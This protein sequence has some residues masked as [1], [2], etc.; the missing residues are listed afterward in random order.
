[1]ANTSLYLLLL[2]VALVA[3]STTH[4]VPTLST[5]PQGLA[6]RLE[7]LHAS[8]SSAGGSDWSQLKGCSIPNPPTAAD[9]PEPWL[10]RSNQTYT[11]ATSMSIP[12]SAR[13]QSDATNNEQWVNT[14]SFKVDFV[15]NA[16]TADFCTRAQ[17]AFISA[18]NRI[19]SEVKIRRP[20]VVGA[21]FFLPCGKSNPPASCAENNVLGAATSLQAIPVKHN[22]DGLV[23]MYPTSLLK[24]TDLMPDDESRVPMPDYDIL[25]QY[26]SMFFFSFSY[27]AH[28]FFHHFFHRTPASTRSPSTGS[29]VIRCPWTP[30]RGIWNMFSR[31]R[32]L[33]IFYM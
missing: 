26:V 15:C 3:S 1:M 30:S 8:S 21:I 27:L 25:A 7:A 13:L 23:Y 5:P 32:Y 17:K 24:Q 6:A 14:T 16:G 28:H 2:A 20:I 22:D 10:E 33:F 12:G 19:A 4:A 9:D 18:C 11:H 31:T 29:K